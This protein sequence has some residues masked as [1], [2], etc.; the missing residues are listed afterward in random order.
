MQVAQQ[1]SFPT[2]HPPEIF[3]K[4]R[5]SPLYGNSSTHLILHGMFFPL[6][7]PLPPTFFVMCFS[8][9]L[10][11]STL[12]SP[13]TLPCHTFPSPITTLHP[14]ATVKSQLAPSVLGVLQMHLRPPRFSGRGGIFV[15]SRREPSAYRRQSS[16]QCWGS[17][18]A[19]QPALQP[20]VQPGV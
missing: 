11:L 9:F 2:S 6:P 3:D 19:S 10:R 14:P 7:T 5:L 15:G 1:K 16:S 13:P 20:N 17:F 4:S 18:P 12:S 8:F